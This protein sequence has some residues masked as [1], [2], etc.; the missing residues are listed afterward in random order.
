MLY[1]GIGDGGATLGGYPEVCQL[2]QVW[3][4]VIRID[5]AGNNSRNGH[6]GIPADNPW[7]DGRQGALPEAWAYGFRNPH[8]ISWDTSGSHMFITDIGQHC[9]EE[10]NLGQAGANY[11]WPHREGT[12]VFT[13][14]SDPNYVYPL[15]Q[16]DPDSYTYPVAQ[17]DHAEGN[18]II[19]GFVYERD[20]LPLLKG[21]YVFGDIVSGKLYFVEN[22]SLVPGQQAQIYSLDVQFEGKAT[23]LKTINQ[24]E[25]VSLRLGM[26]DAGRLYLMTQ[27]DGRVYQIT[28]CIKADPTLTSAYLNPQ[29]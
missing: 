18:A 25:K 19:G 9:V 10:L 24:G 3:G 21:K 20:D 13:L 17:Y 14:E 2:A 22:D 26:D 23:D 27:S 5:P 12:F 1:L 6:Y 29:P 11:G 16:D 7:A 28:D 8:R 4:K 15:P